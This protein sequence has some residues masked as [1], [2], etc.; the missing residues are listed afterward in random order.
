MNSGAF[1][2]RGKTDAEKRRE[3]LARKNDAKK[4]TWKNGVEKRREKAG[5]AAEAAH[6]GGIPYIKNLTF[7]IE[8]RTCF[9]S[10][11]K[12]CDKILPKIC[13]KT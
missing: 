3:K 9:V 1:L 2:N 7:R 10:S 13:E 4:T 5:A 12:F 6:S 8:M 11:F